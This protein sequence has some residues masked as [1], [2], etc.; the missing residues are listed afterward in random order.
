KRTVPNYRNAFDY[1]DEDDDHDE[2]IG[3]RR[4]RDTRRNGKTQILIVTLF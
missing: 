4:R 3:R 1:M 2:P